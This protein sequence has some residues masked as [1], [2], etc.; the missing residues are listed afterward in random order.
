MIIRGF[1]M[2]NPRHLKA[3][4]QRL[5]EHDPGVF[6]I[7]LKPQEPSPRFKVGQFLHLALDSFVR[8]NGYWP[9][10]RVFSIASA[11]GADILRIVYSVKGRYTSR[12]RSELVA[13]KEV[14]LKFPFGDFIVDT[15]GAEII[16]LVAGGTGISAFVG[17]MECEERSLS[18]VWLYY[19]VRNA[20]LVI[21]SEELER[22]ISI[23][24]LNSELSIEEDISDMP[25]APFKKKVGRLDIDAIHGKHGSNKSTHYYLSGPPMM[26]ETFR[27]SLL[28]GSV[29]LPNIHVDAWE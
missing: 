19:G 27:T 1:N 17:L 28:E 20:G 4:V 22:A 13:G 10:S 25:M 23:G 5:I 3:I 24:G 9:E 2:A 12:M 29:T 15:K 8:E 26:V 14:W 11:P 18:S 21:F 7:W 16:V 6:S